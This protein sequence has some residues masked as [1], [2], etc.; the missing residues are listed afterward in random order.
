[1][2]LLPRAVSLDL[3]RYFPKYVEFGGLDDDD[4]DGDDWSSHGSESGVHL[5]DPNADKANARQGKSLEVLLAT[6]NK[7]LLEE[8][9]R[10]RVRDS[11]RSLLIPLHCGSRRSFTAPLNSR[12]KPLEMSSRRRVRSCPNTSRSTKSW[13]RIFLRWTSTPLLPIT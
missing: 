12:S 13:K 10:F 1:M 5:P 11:A 8:L 6:K 7:R 2:F 4:A 9:I 3:T